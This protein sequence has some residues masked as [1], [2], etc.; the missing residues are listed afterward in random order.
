MASAM[1]SAQ[2]ARP[3][4]TLVTGS[5]VGLAAVAKAEWIQGEAP[6]GFEDDKVYVFECWATW[7]GPCIAVIP[8]VN[9]LHKKYYD[10]GL[11]IFGMNVW[12]DGLEKVQNFVK[13]KG[14]GMSYPVAYTG[15]GS[16]FENHWLKAA[17]VTGIPR[18]FV[19][20]KGKLEFTCHPSQL[21]EKIVESLLEG[22]E[23]AK[24]AAEEIL[25]ADDKRR[26]TSEV[27]RDFRMAAAKGDTETMTTKIE[28]FTA[29][30]PNSIYKP[31]MVLDLHVAKKDWQA[32]TQMI[33]EIPAGQARMMTVTMMANR[34]AMQSQMDV[35]DEFTKAL[36]KAYQ[37]AL[38]EFP[39]R[40]RAMEFTILSRLQW[41]IG[42]KEA[43]LKSAKQASEDAGKQ[44]PGSGMSPLPFERFAKAV[45][46]GEM[47]TPVDFSKWM[48]EAMQ[49]PGA[50][51]E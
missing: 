11:R 31:S 16:D 5:P 27:L 22:D 43:A 26:K 38:D 13:N 39:A 35:P 2:Q 24:K 44:P 15:K 19:V 34:I 47:P 32:A 50:A 1:V 29:L 36:A 42:D 18:A 17:G 23:G 6:T 12:E 3:K 21:S 9:E 33:G 45:E 28:E 37:G 41:R 40:S 4:P 30:D 20:R 14:D 49:E 25:S 7:C 8:H 46:A 48:R 10:K 51:A